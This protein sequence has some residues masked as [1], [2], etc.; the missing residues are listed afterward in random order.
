M[1]NELLLLTAPPAS[2]KTYLINQ[3]ME[4]LHQ[5]TL[6]IVPLRALANE[7]TA[8]WGERCLVMT[9][10]E[11]LVKKTRSEV[12]IFDEFH[13]FFYWGDTFRERM[14]ECFYEATLQSRLC[15]LL[16]ATMTQ[17][18]LEV[19]KTYE[20]HFSRI[21]WVDVG[22]QRLKNL[23]CRYY[24]YP[25]KN[26]LDEYFDQLKPKNGTGLIFCQYRHEVKVWEEKIRKKQLTCWSCVGGEAGQFSQLA[27]TG[28]VPDF[29][30]ATTVLSHGVNLPVISRIYF[31][32]QVQN[33]DFW[34]QM[35]ARGGRR[36]EIFDVF[37]LENPAGLEWNRLT[38]Y[39]AIRLLTLKMS[40]TNFFLAIQEWFLK[41]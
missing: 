8:K 24:K 18:M 34:I 22:N 12:V 36:G 27:Q 32:Y 35:V 21:A 5:K 7:L 23:P 33:L 9:P 25:S 31:T 39:L 11:W 29:I 38:N 28:V 37:A 4:D 40:V 41:A 14:W 1:Y 2:G 3:L 13:L 16:T 17:D 15:L 26:W 19:F 10:E 6:V 30:V 20:C